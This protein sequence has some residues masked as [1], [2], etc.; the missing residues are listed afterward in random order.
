MPHKSDSSRVNTTGWPAGPRAFTLIELLIVLVIIGLLIGL[1]AAV[2]AHVLAAQKE[3]VTKSVMQTIGTAIDQFATEDPLKLIYNRPKDPT[4]GP[5]PPYVLHAD[6]T[7]PIS[8]AG[9]LEPR[10]NPRQFPRWDSLEERFGRDFRNV[11]GRGQM[12]GTESIKLDSDIAARRPAPADD[13]RALYT[14]LRA[15]VPEGL[16]Q[17]SER[18]I[19]KFPHA[20][21]TFDEG[22]FVKRQDQS[23]GLLEFGTLEVLGFRDAWGVPFDYFLYVKLD[24]GR[25]SSNNT[26]LIVTK[27]VPVLRS[28]GISREQFDALVADADNQWDRFK[29]N[30]ESWILSSEMPAPAANIDHET[31]GFRGDLTRNEGLGWAQARGRNEDYKYLPHEHE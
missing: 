7:D 17:L 24:V 29:P 25:D 11:T 30:P 28:L 18:H 5:Y 14:Y 13:N 22:E 21:G 31:G 8:V 10:T 4:F 12:P 20:V 19:Q 23:G 1:I 2:A 26:K 27:R 9:A 15:Y 3:H 16:N 6:G